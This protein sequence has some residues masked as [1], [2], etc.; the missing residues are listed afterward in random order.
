MWLGIILQAVVGATRKIDPARWVERHG[1]ILFR[2]ALVRLRNEHEAENLVQETF[3][4]GLKAME[5]F[6]GRS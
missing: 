2:Y 4:A 1:D 5:G 3:L 6:S